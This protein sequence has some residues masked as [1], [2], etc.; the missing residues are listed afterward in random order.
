MIMLPLS[1]AVTS[2]NAHW[3]QWQV[4]IHLADE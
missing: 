3:L 2:P 1:T 4:D